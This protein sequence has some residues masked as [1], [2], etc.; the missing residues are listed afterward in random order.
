[1]EA[2]NR[3]WLFSPEESTTLPAWVDQL[4]E[5]V[6]AAQQLSKAS[7]AD[8]ADGAGASAEA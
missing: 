5:I 6:R 7:D 4:Q 1:M 3:V 8:T 2:N